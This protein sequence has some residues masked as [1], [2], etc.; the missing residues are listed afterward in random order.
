MS[1]AFVILAAGTGTR[2]GGEPKQ[3]RLL[4]GRPVWKWSVEPAWTLRRE[5]LIDRIV[6]VLPP[7]SALPPPAGV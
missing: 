6:L 1:R 5:K 4:G 2:L 3:F 7:E